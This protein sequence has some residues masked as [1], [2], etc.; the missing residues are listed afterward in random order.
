[1]ESGRVG[2][3]LLERTR[4]ARWRIFMMGKS[5]IKTR[6]DLLFPR[7]RS[8]GKEECAGGKKEERDPFFGRQEDWENI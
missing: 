5:Q 7:T 2:T 4:K 6:R 1:M 3:E 8:P